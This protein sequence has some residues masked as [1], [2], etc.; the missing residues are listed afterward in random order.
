[1]DGNDDTAGYCARSTRYD[2]VLQPWTGAILKDDDVGYT[3]LLHTNKW[4]IVFG[5]Q[6][7]G[8]GMEAST[9][10]TFC[11]WVKNA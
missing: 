11:A 5:E 2:Q 8:L 6:G 3:Y 1:M 4:G 10:E 7:C 9:C